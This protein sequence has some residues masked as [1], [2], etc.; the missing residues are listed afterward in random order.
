MEAASTQRKNLVRSLDPRMKLLLVVVISTATMFTPSR[1]VV[2]WNYIII[3]LLWLISGE[4]R[5]AIKFAL[6]F[7]MVLVVEY[8]SLW[9]PN[10]TLKMMVSFVLFIV[11][12]SLSMVIMC[13][14]MSA[15]L[16]VDDLITSLQN[17]HIPKGFTITVAVVFRYIPTIGREFRNINNTMKMRGIAF[18]AK[19]LFFQPGRTM[20]YALVPLIMRSIKVADD[21]SASAM[22]RGLDLQTKRTSYREVRLHL[23][24][25]LITV[26][27]VALIL[28]GRYLTP[29][30]LEGR[31]L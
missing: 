24:D 29:M 26:L 4:V 21:L 13:L 28:V 19:N 8:A 11:A 17:M 31:L 23:H 9:I 30:L 16:C 18:N 5:H 2:A 1:E 15:G 14:W 12:R 20:E 6:I 27:F 3:I 10:D 25:F 22:T 7:A